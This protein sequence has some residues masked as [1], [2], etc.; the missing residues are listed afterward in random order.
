MLM[1]F[2]TFLNFLLPFF[3]VEPREK[4]PSENI[5]TVSAF[6]GTYSNFYQ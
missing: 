3:I 5:Q 2:S 6:V 1:S 4:R